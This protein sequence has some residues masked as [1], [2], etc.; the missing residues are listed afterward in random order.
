MAYQ[1][2]GNIYSLLGQYD[3]AIEYSFINLG[4][5]IFTHGNNNSNVGQVYQNLGSFYT[6]TEKFD[7]ALFYT[8]K[9]IENFKN[10]IGLSHSYEIG[11]AHV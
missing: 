1:A 4:I 2:I 6:S 11:R 9:S 3:K 5:Q 7:K 8:Q 10:N